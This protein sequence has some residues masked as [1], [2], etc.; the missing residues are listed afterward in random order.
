VT[1]ID[2]PPG[3]TA[4]RTWS[5]DRLVAECLQG[6][7]AA[8]AALI[9]KYKRL[10]YSVPF[11]YHATPEDAADIFQ[12]VCLEL[13]RSLHTLRE[14]G[15]LR[16]WLVTTT[17]HQCF[18]WKKRWVRRRQRE[19]T[20]LDD[21]PGE[22]HGVENVDVLEELERDQ[23]VRESIG[24]LSPRCQTIIDLLFFADPPTPYRDLAERL[25]LAVGSLGF[26]R[27]RCL[28]KLRDILASEGL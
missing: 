14:T 6:N 13:Y 10:I 19:G 22:S 20:P 1:E 26:I 16:S 8:W 15:G 27:G 7:E 5:D 25:G 24:R 9:E 3:R 4:E 23:R 21:A 2:A 28:K 18:H 11:R 12:A 17:R